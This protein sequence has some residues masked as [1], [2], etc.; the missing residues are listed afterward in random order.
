MKRAIQFGG[1]ALWALTSCNWD[2]GACWSRAE[3]DG[4]TGAGGGPI[5]PGGGGFGEEPKRRVETASEGE[6]PCDVDDVTELSAVLCGPKEWGADC[7]IRCAEG[8]VACPAGQR[9]TVAKVQVLLYKCCACKGK[10]ECWY[11]DSEDTGNVC[12]YRP[13]TRALLC[14]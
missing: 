11:A 3:E 13:E 4:Q 14:K 8:G 2:E 10:Q 6:P 7:M 12:V 1:L 9:H 5:V